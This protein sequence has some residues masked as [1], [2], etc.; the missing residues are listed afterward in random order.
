MLAGRALAEESFVRAE[1]SDVVS[2]EDHHAACG[3]VR[4][5][6]RDHRQDLEDLPG[7]EQE[8]GVIGGAAHRHGHRDLPGLDPGLDERGEHRL[9]LAE[10]APR[11]LRV[12]AHA[13]ANALHVRDS[14]HRCA[15][16]ATLVPDEIV[17]RLEAIDRHAHARDADVARLPRAVHRHPLAS[18]DD[19]DAH[20]GPRDR[21]R[22][23][24]PAFVEVGLATDERDLARAHRR[25]LVDEPKRL[26]GRELAGARLARARAAMNAREVAPK[27]QLPHDVRGR[28]ARSSARTPSRS[29][30]RRRGPPAEYAT[31]S[32][33]RARGAPDT[34]VL[35]RS[36]R[37]HRRRG[38]PVARGRCAVRLRCGRRGRGRR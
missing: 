3:R 7:L 1:V 2:R 32:I 23:V 27:S 6:A 31:G 19:P 4:V 14:L 12:C 5:D 11:D 34:S 30:R 38:H 26:G 9:D 24:E 28:A 16:S 21:A 35:R 15:M 17:R 20:P 18:G 33:R 10:R 8:L 37:R 36:D 25:D 22:D 13:E 29:G